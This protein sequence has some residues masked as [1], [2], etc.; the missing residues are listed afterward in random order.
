MQP[1]IGG[2]ELQRIL[3]RGLLGGLWSIDQFNRSSRP[4]EHVLPQ[5]GFLTE[6]PQFYDRAFRDMEAFAQGVGRRTWF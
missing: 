1:L 5:P 3:E 2:P 6:H 4:G